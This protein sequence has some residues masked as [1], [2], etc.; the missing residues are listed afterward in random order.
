MNE[1]LTP[2][3]RIF[4]TTGSSEIR[5]WFMNASRDGVLR[6]PPV[7]F[8]PPNIAWS[9]DVKSH[10]R[11]PI[12]E[13]LTLC[14]SSLSAALASS[15]KRVPP[16]RMLWTKESGEDTSSP[17]VLSLSFFFGCPLDIL[18]HT[19]VSPGGKVTWCTSKYHCC[20]IRRIFAPPYS[21]IPGRPFLLFSPSGRFLPLLPFL[22]FL[23]E[24][25]SVA[26]RRN[27][28]DGFVH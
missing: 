28:R 20:T 12:S 8:L 26:W 17:S 21:P 5:R 19:H 18:S 14:T 1:A 24:S 15:G 7:P 27:L 23:P 6:S 13:S 4:F 22:P 11:Q 3:K 10:R 25:A 9:H 2:C 16:R